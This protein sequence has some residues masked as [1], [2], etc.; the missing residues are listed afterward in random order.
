VASGEPQ[1][2]DGWNAMAVLAIFAQSR[3]E[4]IRDA[5]R[6][7]RDW[8]P[9]WL[10]D[11]HAACQVLIHHPYGTVDQLVA[12]HDFLDALGAK[13]EAADVLDQ[14]L[15]RFPTAPELHARLRRRILADQGVGGLE[16]AYEELLAEPDAPAPLLWYAGRASFVAAEFQR[17]AGSDTQAAAAYERA[18]AWFEKDAAAEPEQREAVDHQVAMAQAGRARLA[19]EAGDLDRALEA[20]LA[21]FARDPD[22]AA[23]L[24]GLNI[25]PVD[26]AFMLRS[27]LQEQERTEQVARLQEALNGLDPKLLELPAYEGEG[28]TG[29]RFRPRGGPRDGRPSGN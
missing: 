25:S 18:I 28:P 4:A 8:P 20:M 1:D 14:G 3:Q 12:Y 22:G 16:P 2:Q 11:V 10:A 15:A 5:I 7:K 17:R 9:E 13:S 24:D 23:T 6:N 29:R 21:S 26:T 27:R 19:L